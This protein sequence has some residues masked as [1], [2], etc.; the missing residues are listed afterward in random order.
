MAMGF[1]GNHNGLQ[2]S[3]FNDAMAR[4][5]EFPDRLPP[6][7]QFGMLMGED[8]KTRYRR[9]YYVKGDEPGAQIAGGL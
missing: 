3:A 4:W 2:W 7:L 5:R 6:N 9:H 1:G 8:A